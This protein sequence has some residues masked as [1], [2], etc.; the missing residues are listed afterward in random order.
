MTTQI[1]LSGGAVHGIGRHLCA[2]AIDALPPVVCLGRNRNIA[3]APTLKLSEYVDQ[4]MAVA[5]SAKS[6]DYYTK[7]AP[8]IA[9]VLGNDR[10]GDCVIASLLHRLGVYTAND[11]DSGGIVVATEQEATS[12]YRAFCGPGDRGC[13]IPAVLDIAR[14]QG[15]IAAGNRYKIDGYASIDWRSKDLVKAALQL[16]GALCIGINLPNAWTQNG[17]WDVT[18]TGIV[19]GHDVPPLGHGDGVHVLNTNSDG[20][21]I[22]SWGRLYLITWPAFTS[23]RWVEECYC[24]LSPNWTNND[25]LAPSGVTVNELKADLAKLANGTLPDVPDPNNDPTTTDWF[26]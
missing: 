7:A 24:I 12:Q 23:T 26:V 4:A 10:L 18:T 2:A 6:V 8:S 14:S 3:F 17:I 1:T 19:G 11:P 13:N 20:V 5:A 22:A 16:F 21:V 15:Y 9:Q 25:Q